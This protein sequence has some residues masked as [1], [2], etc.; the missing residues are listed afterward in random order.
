MSEENTKIQLKNLSDES[1]RLLDDLDKMVIKASDLIP[2]VYASLKKD[3]LNPQQARLLIE[4][5]IEI[6]QRRL[7]ELIP[8]E[9]KNQ[10]MIRKVSGKLSRSSRQLTSD[11]EEDVKKPNIPAARY[12]PVEAQLESKTEPTKSIENIF[13]KDTVNPDQECVEELEEKVVTDSYRDNRDDRVLELENR[14]GLKDKEIEE[15]KAKL[16]STPTIPKHNK[17]IVSIPRYS[18]ENTDLRTYL[19]DK[20]GIKLGIDDNKVVRVWRGNVINKITEYF[21][22]A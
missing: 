6:S 16:A 21:L 22:N 15:L 1:Q 13:E 20:N 9:A 2:R 14:L 10:R 11:I 5:R 18:Q 8:P 17:V 12:N 3:G 4:E 19:D 7:E